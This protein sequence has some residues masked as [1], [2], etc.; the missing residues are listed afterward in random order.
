MNSGRIQILEQYAKEDPNDPFPVYALGLELAEDNP[1][2]AKELF[3]QVMDQHPDYVPVYYHA[4]LLAITQSEPERARVIAEK[5][6]EKAKAASDGKA[7]AE[8]RSLLEA[9]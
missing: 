5:G 4:A 2:R 8:L 6:I 9:D 7:V 3:S 1:A